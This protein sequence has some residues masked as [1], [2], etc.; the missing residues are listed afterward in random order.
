MVGVIGDRGVVAERV[1]RRHAG[2][3][4]AGSSG[5]MKIE[6]TPSEMREVA[7]GGPVVA[8]GEVT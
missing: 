5:I 3:H 7:P 2:A 4:G 6:A 1:A 8:V